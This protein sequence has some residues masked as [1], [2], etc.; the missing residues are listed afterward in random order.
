MNMKKKADKNIEKSGTAMDAAYWIGHVMLAGC[1]IV[2]IYLAATV[3]FQKAVQLELL[4]SDREGYYL[5]EAFYS[6]T[7]SNI[8][9]LNS[10]VEEFQATAYSPQQNRPRLNQY[11]YNAMEFSNATFEVRPVALN[12]VSEYYIGVTEL[13][14]KLDNKRLGKSFALRELKKRSDELSENVM[15]LLKSDAETLREKLAQ[16]GVDAE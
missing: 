7:Q 10:F 15:K 9:K 1:T 2:G 16:H 3:G 14:D 5:T 8:E 13:L 6:E 11:V 4:K 12:G